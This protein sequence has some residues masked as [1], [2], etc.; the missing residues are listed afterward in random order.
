M[1]IADQGISSRPFGSLSSKKRS[2]SNRR[3]NSLPSQGPPNFRLRSTR[4]R[5]TSTSTHSGSVL[6]NKS[7]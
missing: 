2:S 6:V 4:T 1:A 3:S 5:F 7:V